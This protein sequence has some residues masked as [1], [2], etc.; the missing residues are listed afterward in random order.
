MNRISKIWTDDNAI[1]FQTED[2]EVFSQANK[3]KFFITLWRLF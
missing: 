3:V 2:G 1:Y